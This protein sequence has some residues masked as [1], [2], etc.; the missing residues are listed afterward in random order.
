MKRLQ[1]ISIL[2]SGVLSI[3][4]LAG[5]A[6]QTTAPAQTNTSSPSTTQ[7]VKSNDPEKSIEFIVPVAAGGGADIFARTIVKIATDNKFCPQ[8]IVVV[9][10]PGGSSSIGFSYV[11][12]KKADPYIISIV[13]SSY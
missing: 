4:L 12:E 3:T 1:I 10:K 6:K 8:P 9:N 7:Q 2:V 11:A 5:C 13:N